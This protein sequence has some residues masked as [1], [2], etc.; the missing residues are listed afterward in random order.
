MSFK[1]V[2]SKS[3]FDVTVTPLSMYEFLGDM[4]G[5]VMW[6]DDES[7]LNAAL[8]ADVHYVNP[9]E[10]VG[11][12]YS[13]VCYDA[14]KPEDSLK[15]V[16]MG[17]YLLDSI[18]RA[19]QSCQTRHTISLGDFKRFSLKFT[20]NES[21]LCES[22]E[23]TSQDISRD[24]NDSRDF[25]NSFSGEF[26]D[27]H[28]SSISYDAICAANTLCHMAIGGAVLAFNMVSSTTQN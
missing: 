17:N 8:V 5:L 26:S 16:M 3:M 7:P 27:I 28:G 4:N 21:Q 9:N 20:I 24:E 15:V 18:K 6:V 25:G 11:V 12:D 19:A 22:V 23:F 13:A 14:G 10:G 1:D 2:D